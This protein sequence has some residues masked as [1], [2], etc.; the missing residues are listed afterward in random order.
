MKKRGSVVLILIL[1]VSLINF[2]RVAGRD[3]Y[4]QTDI[5]EDARIT[6]A[7]GPTY[8]QDTAAELILDSL[9]IGY[10]EFNLTNIP[11]AAIIDQVSLQ[12]TSK[13]S[14][15][16]QTQNASFR[17]M[18]THPSALAD[19]NASNSIIYWDVFNDTIYA[20]NKIDDDVVY[21]TYTK[22]LVGAENDVDLT[23]DYFVVGVNASTSGGYWSV[24]S[25]I[26]T[27]PPVLIIHYYLAGD[28]Q[29]PFTGTYFENGTLTSPV[30]VTADLDTGMETF[31][32]NGSNTEYYAILPHTWYW[33]IGGGYSRFIHS[34]DNESLVVTVPDGTDYVYTFTVKDLTGNLGTD[35]HLEAWRIINGTETLITREAIQLPNAVPLNLVFGRTY[36]LKILYGDHTR[37]N[38]GFF[39]T[40]SDLSTTL[41][42]RSVE[43]TDGAQVLY[44]YITVEA[45]RNSG[46]ITVAYLD[47]RANTVWANVSVRIRNGAEVA[48]YARSNNTYSITYTGFDNSLGYIVTVA[49]EHSDFGIWGRTFILDQSFSFPSPPVLTGIFGSISQNFI[50]LI[51]VCISILVFPVTMQPIGLLAGG[52]VASM[53]KFFAW[54]TWSYDLLAFYWFIAILINL[55]MRGRGT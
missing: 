18:S 11:D 30:E 45:L 7:A 14:V 51:L 37:Y 49:G 29:I 2:P 5:L 32:S 10:F 26:G 15:A 9:R 22:V 53:L 8:N 40:G 13:G 28:Y 47:D 16:G 43:F 38:Y 55:V 31:W 6:K 36:I 12:F 23:K 34:Y 24:Y 52:V 27:T 48:T 3:D 35:S 21:D 33:D 4:E 50:P 46:I 39:Q 25:S 20:E 44:N 41:L 54:S 1:L 42:I 19:N 17:K